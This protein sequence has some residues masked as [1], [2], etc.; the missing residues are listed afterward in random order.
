LGSRFVEQCTLCA[1][2]YVE[3]TVESAGLSRIDRQDRLVARVAEELRARILSGDIAPGSR[4]LQ[5]DI[6]AALGV[7][8]TPLREALQILERD[9]LVEIQSNNRAVVSTLGD[10]EIR[11]LLDVREMLDGLAARL[12]AT[13]AVS[14]AEITNEQSDLVER[15][16]RSS[17][18]LNPSN[19]L[20][21][22]VA[23]HSNLYVASGN[24]WLSEHVGLV[25]ISAQMLYA[26]LLSKP[27]RIKVSADE[28]GDILAAIRSGDPDKAE[29]V[30]RAHVRNTKKAWTAA[31]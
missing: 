9:R 1:V 8:R 13:R 29:D 20:T 11:Q 2:Y 18:P 28:H 31:Q 25:Q 12:L 17:R 4:L 19:F 30:A 27:D 21:A 7:S 16:V 5:N 24:A 26:K 22:H 15:L 10:S 23:F 14:S 3:M 6:A